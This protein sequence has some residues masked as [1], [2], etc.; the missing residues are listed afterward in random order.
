MPRWRTL[1]CHLSGSITLRDIPFWLLC[2]Y[3]TRCCWLI[4]RSSALS[5]IPG[6]LLQP[7][8]ALLALVLKSGRGSPNPYIWVFT[9]FKPFMSPGLQSGH[10]GT[11]FLFSAVSSAAVAVPC[12]HQFFVSALQSAHL[13]IR[14]WWYLQHTCFLLN[15][16]DAV[17]KNM[18]GKYMGET[19]PAA[20]QPFTFMPSANFTLL[21]ES[22]GDGSEGFH[23]CPWL[24]WV[25]RE[26]CVKAK[27]TEFNTRGCCPRTKLFDLNSSLQWQSLQ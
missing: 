26:L 14:L 27:C 22:H 24:F 7:S 18:D 23:W 17:K 20:E 8:G 19:C 12:V 21:P 5:E 6:L 4:S 13:Q 1:L 16:T 2:L 25:G 9:P 3:E 10:N 11:A 15:F